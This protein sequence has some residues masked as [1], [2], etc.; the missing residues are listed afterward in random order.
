MRRSLVAASALLIPLL[1]AGNA[2]ADDAEQ[3]ARAADALFK[4]AR[5]LV[6][7]QRAAEACPKLEESQRLD[8][9][10]GTQFYLADCYEQTGRIAHAWA[11]F[12]D[13]EGVLVRVNDPRAKPAGERARAIEPRVPKVRVN[14]AGMSRLKALAVIVDDHPVDNDVLK[15]PIPMEVGR[16]AIEVRAAG[17]LPRRQ[18][19]IVHESESLVVEVLALADEPTKRVVVRENAALGSQRVSAIA[20]GG[21]GAAAI[22]TGAVLVAV[23]KAR[24]DDATRGC[25]KSSGVEQCPFSTSFADDSARAHSA[26]QTANVGTGV[27][28]GGAVF[29]AV[30]AVLWFTGA[31]KR[32]DEKAFAR[33]FYAAPNVSEHDTGFILG[34]AF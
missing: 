27:I 14:V 10:A 26:T 8:P 1:V 15:S 24:F 12:H 29:L 25:T 6:A 2:H 4:E 28:I 20:T 9:G 7:A 34:G 32:T 5:A 33:T 18:E 3:R 21:V 23:E 17:K 11:L 30:G 19:I 13:L 16:H 22:I 31:P